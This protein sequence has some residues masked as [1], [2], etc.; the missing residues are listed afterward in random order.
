M[1]VNVWSLSGDLIAI[2]QAMPSENVADLK[3]KLR[4]CGEISSFHK[5]TFLLDGKCL[6]DRACL[7]EFHLDGNTDLHLIRSLKSAREMLFCGREAALELARQYDG[8]A[9]QLGEMIHPLFLDGQGNARSRVAITEVLVALSQKLWQPQDYF[10]LAS[11]K[12]VLTSVALDVLRESHGACE[13][14][15]WHLHNLMRCFAWLG[16]KAVCSSF[17]CL[18][19]LGQSPNSPTMLR[20]K[21]EMESQFQNLPMPTLKEV[22]CSIPE[23]SDASAFAQDRLRS[24]ISCATEKKKAAC[25]DLKIVRTRKR[26]PKY[27]SSPPAPTFPVLATCSEVLAAVVRETFTL[28]DDGNE[29]EICIYNKNRPMRCSGDYKKAG[30]AAVLAAIE[31]EPDIMLA[32]ADRSLALAAV[33]KHPSTYQHLPETLKMDRD[34]L[35]VALD[36]DTGLR[37]EFLRTAGA[38]EIRQWQWHARELHPRRKK[39]H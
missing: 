5:V 28:R 24:I 9:E 32:H 11:L 37:A 19:E 14:H 22:L 20:A 13:L 30:R 29:V 18:S 34:I 26:M 21:S 8:L 15:P 27:D 33:R 35:H 2:L 7:E 6:E 16:P 38:T 1:A 23:N 25:N 4:D 31:Q 17:D 3:D 39:A 10:G 12:A 36:Q